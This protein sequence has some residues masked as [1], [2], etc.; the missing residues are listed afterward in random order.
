M[1]V[2]E[3]VEFHSST[4]GPCC[5]EHTNVQETLLS[6]SFP[7]KMTGSEDQSPANDLIGILG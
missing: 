6:S 4:L 5:S 3:S 7:R 2:A 1:S